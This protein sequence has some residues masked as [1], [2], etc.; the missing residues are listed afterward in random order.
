MKTKFRNLLT[1]IFGLVLLVSIFS[2]V[3][4]LGVTPAR[5]IVDYS[6][7]KEE[8]ISFSVVN[9]ENK[10]MDIVV[11]VQGELNQ[12]VYLQET[13]FSMSS[14]ESSKQM[15]YTYRLP[16]S[17]RPGPHQADIVILQLP[18]RGANGQAF[19]G[20]AVAVATQLVVNVPYPGKY[21][22][23]DL[24]I[25]NPGQGE[26]ATFI[27]PVVSLGEQD[28]AR[29][30][31]NIDIYNRLGEK[32]AS[33]NTAEVSVPSGQRSDIVSKWKADVP[34]GEYLAKATLIYDGE[35]LTL[36]KQFTVGSATLELQQIQVR[37]FSLG[38]IAKFEMLVENKWSDRIVGVYAE[39]QVYNKD[40]E[41]IADFKSPTYDIPSL[42]KSNIVSYWDT[43]G[44]RTGTY[45]TT[46]YLRY[47]DKSSQ[48]NLQLKVEQSS[49]TAVGLGFVISE[50]SSRGGSGS[51]VTIL[52]VVI[53][54][55]VLINLA[56]FLVLRKRLKK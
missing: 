5:T 12:S 3:S 4:A 7:G 19:V 44:I 50:S 33:F 43:A 9:T 10:N 2:S 29:V 28:L 56:W 36:E 15:S 42:E 52:V 40:N 34:V 30:Q 1:L 48:Q 20:A 11:Y 41:V 18:E 45:D 13:S 23:S 55:L 49:I 22:Q 54:L 53:V 31:A 27:I 38:E 6:P 46:V 32:V 51:I 16:S 26:E 39:T 8:T 47:G 37:D 35:T 14:S 24:N 21:A 25:V 17:L